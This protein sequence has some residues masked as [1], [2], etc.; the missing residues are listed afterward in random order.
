MVRIS[1]FGKIDT[2]SL[3]GEISMPLI[4]LKQPTERSFKYV[5]FIP[6]IT[7]SDL[8][9]NNLEGC[10]KKLKQEANKILKN[11]AKNNT[12]FPF[13]PNKEEILQTYKN[14]EEIYFLKIK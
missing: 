3:T 7:A 13:F 6:A 12:E 8:T 2:L 4:I 11:M 14:V 10:K 1:S 5:G 9:D